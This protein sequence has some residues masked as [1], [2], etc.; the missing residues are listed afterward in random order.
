MKTFTFKTSI[1]CSGC[2][3]KVTP[4][5][6]RQLAPEEWNVNILTPEKILTVSSDKVTAKEVV[7]A[8]EQAGFGI[9][10]IKD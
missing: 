9:E 6:N 8:V 10:Q 5:L 1:K 7:K 4:F 3:E 2:I